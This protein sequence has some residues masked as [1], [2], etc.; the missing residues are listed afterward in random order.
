ML[1]SLQS[2]SVIVVKPEAKLAAED[3]KYIITARETKTYINSDF[4]G[5]NLEKSSTVGCQ[6]HCT[7]PQEQNFEKFEFGSF[8]LQV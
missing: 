3:S 6:M 8:D 5:S 1:S 7:S 4:T 2:R